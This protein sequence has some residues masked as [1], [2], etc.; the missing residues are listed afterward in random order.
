MRTSHPL[1]ADLNV[2]D[3]VNELPT[4]LHTYR[5]KS[6]CKAVNQSGPINR[7]FLEYHIYILYPM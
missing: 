2:A 5:K 3:R 7:V 1:L 6:V 4:Y